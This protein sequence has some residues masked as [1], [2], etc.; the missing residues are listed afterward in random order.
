DV[1]RGKRQQQ[2]VKQIA[3]KTISV[4]SV[5][6]FD[7]LIEAVSDNLTTNLT[8]DNMKSFLAYGIDKD[9]SITPVN[10]EGEGGKKAD[11]YWYYNVDPESRRSIEKELREQ[12]GLPIVDDYDPNEGVV[13]YDGTYNPDHEQP[14]EEQQPE[15]Y[16]PNQGGTNDPN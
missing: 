12:L 14:I 13:P 15:P 10:L 11:G 6:K 5:L 9:V 1:E 16:D 8:F 2:I 4:S 3:K 7:D